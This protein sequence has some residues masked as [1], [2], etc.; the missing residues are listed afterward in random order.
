MNLLWRR[1]LDFIDPRMCVV[2]GHPLALREETVCMACNWQLPRTKYVENPYDN[3]MAKSFYGQF[4]IE[5]A[6]GWFFYVAKDRV[7]QLIYRA[8]YYGDRHLCVWLGEAAA[9][10]FDNHDFFRGIDVI[11]PTPLT[12]RRKWQRG[13]NQS[14]YIARG[15]ARMTGLPIVTNAVRRVRFSKSQTL[16][17]GDERVKNVMNVFELTRPEKLRGKHI[18]LIDDIVTTGA[19]L[20]SCGREIAKAGGVKI[21]VMSIGVAKD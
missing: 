17:R 18:L 5:R 21:S 3:R 14:E 15:V 11:V 7:A 1:I 9:R 19:T 2:C 13:Y 10:E 4:P 12:R 8:K 20:S 6:A 16:L